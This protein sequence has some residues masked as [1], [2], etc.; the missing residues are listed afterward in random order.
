MHTQNLFCQSTYLTMNYYYFIFVKYV[1]C[2]VLQQTNLGTEAT[3]KKLLHTSNTQKS[4][5]IPN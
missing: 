4:V 2:C 5:L 3:I 1:I